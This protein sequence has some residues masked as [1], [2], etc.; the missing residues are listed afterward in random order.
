[1]CAAS[2]RPARARLIETAGPAETE[3]VGAELARE[4]APGDVVLVA[5]ELGSGKTTLVRGAC[6][7][8]GV[9]GAITSPSF[10]IGHIYEGR[11]GPVSHLDLYRLG[12]LDQED[13]ALLSDY[14]GPDRISFV[15][16]PEIAELRL[17]SVRARVRLEHRGGD[18]RDVAIELA[19][20]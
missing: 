7:A 15:E 18:R 2:E 4:L 9:W 8:L 6:W 5:G 13:P 19:E 16:W 11:E 12:G 1:M 3:T 10:T 17:G 20:R 14:V